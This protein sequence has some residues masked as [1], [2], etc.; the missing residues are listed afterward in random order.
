MPSVP[1]SNV[2]N[3]LLVFL[4]QDPIPWYPTPL[5]G[6]SEKWADS[7]HKAQDIVQRMSL[8]EKVNVTTGT[9]WEMGLCVGNTG[10]YFQTTLV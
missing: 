2:S 9:G 6:T 10:G 3:V 7:Y 5:G 4:L 8:A 1:G